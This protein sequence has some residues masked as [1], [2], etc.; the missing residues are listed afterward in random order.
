[1]SDPKRCVR[2]GWPLR[3]DP[4]K[5]CVE[6]NCSYRPEDGSPEY[7][8]LKTFVKC[9]GCEDSYS[10]GCEACP[11]YPNDPPGTTGV[12]YVMGG[13]RDVEIAQ[14]R[15]RGDPLGDPSAR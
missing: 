12:E 4:E 14:I 5:G 10:T 2:C 3:D 11:G 7:A 6:G 1:M 13:P 8:H 9:A 15:E